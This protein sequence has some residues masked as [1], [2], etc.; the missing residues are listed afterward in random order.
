MTESDESSKQ[1]VLSSTEETEEDES[2]LVDGVLILWR[3]RWLIGGVF[4]VAVLTTLIV[5]IRMPKVFMS[6]TTLLI[7]REG[8]SGGILSG[9]GASGLLQQ[10]PEMS[11]PSLTPNRDT[12]TSILKSRRVAQAVAERFRLQERY[13]A[14]YLEDVIGGL[15]RTTRITV[16]KEG[17]I[18]IAVE[19]H[20]PQMAAQIANFYVEQLDQL[21]SQFGTGTS[22][23]RRALLSEQLAR[24]KR[25]LD[26]KE[27]ELRRF[28]ERNRAIVLQDQTRSVIEAAARLKGEIMAAEVQVQVMRTFATEAN[29]DI[30]TLRR[31][32]EEMKRQLAQ[33]EYGDRVSRPQGQSPDRSELSVPF[34][35]VPELGLELA[36]L[37][38]DMKTQEI[39]VMLLSQQ[40]EQAKMSDEARDFPTV[41]VLD[42]AV[43]AVRHSRPNLR[44]N[45][46]VSGALSLVV[47]GLLAFFIEYLKKSSSWWRRT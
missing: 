47:G 5:T 45:L 35:K 37:T 12:L 34:A 46:K 9:L 39:L 18:S 24:R 26:Q 42:R 23:R 15:Q 7:P 29:P 8:A 11:L 36:R 20:D 41:Q 1:V 3:N 40:L 33:V 10:L 25:E 28:Q 30:V 4:F 21:V 32:I 19:D 27:E 17:V 6:T 14:R 44:Y 2:N 22:G 43:P 31:K 13:K 38:R 16:S